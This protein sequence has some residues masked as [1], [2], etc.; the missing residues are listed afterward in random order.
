MN[1]DSLIAAMQAVAAEGPR[2]VKVRGW[3]EVYVRSLTTAEVEEA[4]A[5]TSAVNGKDKMTLARGAAR[6]ICDENGN[7]LFDHK[8]DADLKLLAAQPWDLLRKVLEA[9]DSDV[10]DDVTGN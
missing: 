6:L 10:K 5:E 4:Q 8:S 9:G 1:R 7:R 2:A 3:G